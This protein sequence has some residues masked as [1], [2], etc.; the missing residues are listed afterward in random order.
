MVESQKNRSKNMR[1]QICLVQSQKDSDYYK[2]AKAMG[3]IYY[4]GLPFVCSNC[5]L[6]KINVVKDVQKRKSWH[7]AAGN[8]NWYSQYG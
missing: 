4:C 1:N 3:I 5:L 2:L 6:S 7:I 8:V